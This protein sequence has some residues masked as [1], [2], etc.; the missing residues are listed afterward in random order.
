MIESKSIDAFVRLSDIKTYQ[1][2]KEQR[3]FYI[4]QGYFGNTFV[5]LFRNIQDGNFHYLQKVFD[6]E[7]VSPNVGYY[8]DSFSFQRW[9]LFL[10]SELVLFSD[11]WDNIP[12]DYIRLKLKY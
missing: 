1:N 11:G 6:D 9:R 4:K 2:V 5:E 12:D 3:N 7:E 8:V 10:P